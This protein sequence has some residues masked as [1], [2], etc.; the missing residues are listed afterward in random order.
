MSCKIRHENKLVEKRAC[1]IV[2]N[3]QNK[4]TYTGYDPTP[5]KCQFTELPVT[6]FPGFIL[7][8]F[9]GAKVRPWKVLMGYCPKHNHF[10]TNSKH[11]IVGVFKYVCSYFKDR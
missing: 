5:L 3:K 7:G 1:E 4:L 2:L 11:N 10:L 6:Y 8:G 9:H